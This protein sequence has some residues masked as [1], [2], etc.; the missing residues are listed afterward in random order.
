[1]ISLIDKKDLEKI[2]TQLAT[3]DEQRESLIKKSR[4]IIRLS[5]KIIYAIHRN[6]PD[7]AEGNI[8]DIHLKLKEIEEI[9]KNNPKLTSCGCYKV[10]FQ[11]YVE[12]I[13][14]FEVMKKKKIPTNDR[15][16]IDPEFYLLGITDLTGELVRKAINSAINSDFAT[17]IELKNFVSEL[18]GELMLFDFSN[19]ELRKKFDSIKYDL[20][21]LEELVI[22]IKL[23]AK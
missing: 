6:D 21:K 3:L 18:Y 14:F 7:S 2:R 4:I 19:G 17:A 10:A 11:E 1:M 15:L 12:A 13:A 16:K 5:K 8:K 22:N 23:R 9:G 20:K